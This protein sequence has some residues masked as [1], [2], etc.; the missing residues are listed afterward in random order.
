[1]SA[2]GKRMIKLGPDYIIC[3]QQQEKEIEMNPREMYLQKL[4]T[5]SKSIKLQFMEVTPSQAKIWLNEN[6]DSKNRKS[7]RHKINKYKEEL[8]N[9]NWGFS[10]DEVCFDVNNRLING[11]HRLTACV[12]ADMP[13]FLTIATGFPTDAFQNFD[14]G[15]LRSN[16]QILNIAGID[17][18]NEMASTIRG[19][20][21]ITNGATAAKN[22]G[23][24]NILDHY[25]ENK[26]IYDIGCDC[27]MVLKNKAASPPGVIAGV[28]AYIYECTY[29]K[30]GVLEFTNML[31]YGENLN[32]NHP[33]MYIRE[34]C[35]KAKKSKDPYTG[36]YDLS[37]LFQERILKAWNNFAEGKTMEKFV[38]PKLERSPD[39]KIRRHKSGD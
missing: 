11:K 24:T 21:L 8:Q 7:S 17:H 10:N 37:R 16:G 23:T 25:E 13:M 22:I 32:R 9:L 39:V 38:T 5:E 3:P 36:E 1:V 2:G 20:Q 6:K 33:A 29:D 34:Y 30:T 15:Y 26:E 31:A 28:L 12:E 19:Y 18:S 4:R 14:C 27:Y 35:I